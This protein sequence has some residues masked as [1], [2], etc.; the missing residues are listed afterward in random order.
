ML[1]NLK[2][3][4]HASCLKSSYII[5]CKC[6]FLSNTKTFFFQSAIL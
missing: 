2:F 6:I 3:T 5:S 1:H 4:Q